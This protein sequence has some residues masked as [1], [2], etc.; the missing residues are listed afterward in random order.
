[1]VSVYPSIKF[2][3]IVILVSIALVVLSQ[4][5]KR[6]ERVVLSIVWVAYIFIILSMTLPSYDF[7][8]NGLTFAEK[9]NSAPPW[10]LKPF[11]LL[12]GQF[13]NMLEG[14]MGA[15]RQFMGNIILFIPAGFFPP[16]LFPKLRKWYAL[17]LPG[18][19]WSLFIEVIQLI[20]NLAQ[21]GNRSF[22]T[23]DIILN[24]FGAMIGFLIYKIFFAKK[25]RQELD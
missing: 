22:D 19:I 21:L 10:N 18:L 6:F 16:M 24:V 25:H 8:S 9:L 15:I 1:M 17:I 23:D 13:F 4:K 20:L 3:L 11:S 5:T 2:L 7:R 14:Q 12:S